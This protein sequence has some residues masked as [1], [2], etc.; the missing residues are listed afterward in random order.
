MMNEKK[1]GGQPTQGTP[2]KTFA[3]GQGKGSENLGDA[4]ENTQVSAKSSV[5]N[6]YYYKF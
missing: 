2:A 4:Q 1:G 6:N 3:I 5:K